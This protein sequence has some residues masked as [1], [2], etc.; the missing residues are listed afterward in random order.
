MKVAVIGSRNL[1]I[2]LE[3]Y[4]PKNTTE[5]ISG[6]AVGID[7]LAEL[8]AV[9]KKLPI[10]I[11]KPEYNR[12]GKAAPIIRNKLIVDDADMVIA[13]VYKR[14]IYSTCYSNHLLNSN[15]ICLSLIH[16]FFRLCLKSPTKHH[17]SKVNVN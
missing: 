2:D 3:K 15:C 13:D 4:I 9:S 8:Y 5:I 17:T 12:Y 7:T 1:S 14:Q 6:G 16:I 11:Y 10:K